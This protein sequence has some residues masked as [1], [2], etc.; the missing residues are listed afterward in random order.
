VLP[1]RVDPPAFGQTA[2]IGV[3]Y[4]AS[5]SCPI[6]IHIGDKW[7]TFDE[8][9]ND[10]P[11]DISI[12]PFPFSIGATVGMPYPVPGIVTL[13]DA[14]TATFR[15]DVDGSEFPL[16]GRDANPSPGDACL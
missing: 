15:A 7:W 12:P 1:S 3:A 16:S 13:T 6:P 5:V 2:E 8:P 4:A 9:M 10:W 11:A 14:D